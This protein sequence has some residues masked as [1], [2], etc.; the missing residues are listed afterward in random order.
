MGDLQRVVQLGELLV[1]QRAKLVEAEK[2]AATIKATVLQLE[3]ED[4]PALM[5][6]IG[7]SEIRLTNGKKIA[8]QEDCD[9]AI[10]EKNKPAAF[11]WL[12]DN[13]F[14][15]IIKVLVAVQFGKGEHDQAQKVAAALQKKYR[16]NQVAL[17]ENVHPATL[18][19]F[20]KERMTAGEPVPVDLFGVYVYSKAVIKD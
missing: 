19:A 8:V 15:G 3:R 16:N 20:V 14:G 11:R 10:S 13:G 2:A 7:V 18:K 9:A 17:E 4:L 6:E 5:A 1:E 12:L